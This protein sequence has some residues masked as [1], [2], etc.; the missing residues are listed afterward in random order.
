MIKRFSFGRHSFA[1]LACPFGHKRRRN[2]HFSFPPHK[3]RPKAKGG[4]IPGKTT[5]TKEERRE[6]VKVTW[7]KG[8]RVR[9]AI[10]P[11]IQREIFGKGRRRKNGGK[12]K[13]RRLPSKGIKGPSFEKERRGLKIHGF[14]EYISQEKAKTTRTE[15]DISFLGL[16]NYFPTTPSLCFPNSNWRKMSAEKRCRAETTLSQFREEREIR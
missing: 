14:H 4:K 15:G 1:P 12:R 16:R 2:A 9:R 5:T 13:C 8:K 7:G 6:E 11:H 3:M 10:S